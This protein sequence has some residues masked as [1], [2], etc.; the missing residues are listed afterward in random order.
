MLRSYIKVAARTAQKC[1]GYSLINVAGLSIGMAC[2]IMIVLWVTDELRY[3][4]FH[5]R[6]DQ[7][8][9]VSETYD[10][11]G[12]AFAS[13]LTSVPLS[14][15]LRE[16]IPEVERITHV[17][18]PGP[19]IVKHGDVRFESDV[20][21]L[22]DPGF[23]E[24]F[25][26][27]L[28]VGDPSTALSET[29]SVVLTETMARKHFGQKDPLGT[30][31]NV[32][33]RDFVVTGIM[34]DVPR[35][36]HMQ[37]DFVAN[38]DSRPEW[39]KTITD[40]NWTV[41]A[42]Y[43]YVQLRAGADIGAL[44]A[45]ATEINLAH[46]G[47]T[48]GKVTIGFQPLSRIH[49]YHEVE[50]HFEGH[51]EIKYVYLFSALAV[52]TLLVACINFM[53]LSTARSGLRAREVGMRKVVG[54]RRQDLIWQ[55]MGESMVLSLT[56]LVC[57]LA[58]VELFLPVL[59]DFADKEL[60][61]LSS[62]SL[63]LVLQLAG[64][65]LLTGLVAGSYPALMLSSFA[66]V[67]VLKGYISGGEA[68]RT[69]R[70][71]LVTAQFVLAISLMVGTAVIHNQMDFIRCKNLGYDQEHLI[72]FTMRGE[73]GQNYETVKSRLELH[74]SIAGVTAGTPPVR[75]LGPVIE[76]DWD[77]KTDD[78]EIDWGSLAVESNYIKTMGMEITT[79]RD[80]DEDLA[81]NTTQ[82]LV[83]N[84]AAASLLGDGSP[85]GKHM[86]FST[87]MLTGHL[88]HVTYEGKVVG[89]VKDFHHGSMFSSIKPAIFFMDPDQRSRMCVRTAEGRTPEA[90]A[91]LEDLW[92]HYAPNDLFEYYFVDQ[93][94]DSYY[95]S[96]QKLSTILSG[97]TTLALFVTCLG[98]LGLASFAAEQR[99]KEIG[100]RRVLGAT[101]PGIVG[102]F[103]KDTLLMVLLA[104]V[105]AVPPAVWAMGKWLESFAYRVDLDW[106]LPV[107]A[108]ALALLI[109]LVTVGYQAVRAA[110]SNPVNA[111]KHE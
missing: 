99:T 4:S 55:F 96:E 34:A 91:V 89:V 17:H 109:A 35:N 16:G 77:G 29:Y 80:F 46:H 85:L 64:I 102:L 52:L 95:R 7:L 15:A 69:F 63:T 22:A 11:G 66:P 87:H 3:D 33:Q 28:I 50:D 43:T 8:Y 59:N 56:A 60:T 30:V 13:A 98:L 71:I 45:R 82:G 38:F 68:G 9:R 105:I 72:F 42:F 76:V 23:L 31:I 94:I 97:F 21:A 49:L 37:F 36:S 81:H 111:L 61:L 18:V 5:E 107:G 103:L 40:D 24:M 57:A 14:S 74:P 39:L 79:G 88:E 51:G 101:V 58:L 65:S 27:P 44:S 32:D 83:I 41:S 75:N 19:Q 6:I 54:A 67:K 73:F 86:S 106:T 104:G 70:R 62:V 110:M 47:E 26:F 92:S 90:L 108:T 93:S 10:F 25:S 78:T 20:M 84:E 12:E 53:N 1:K 2:C 100:I 48:H